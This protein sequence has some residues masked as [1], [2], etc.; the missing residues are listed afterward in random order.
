VSQSAQGQ[1]IGVAFMVFF[2][3]LGLMRRM[4]PQPVRERR[5]LITG[6][7]V[8]VAIGA[9]L[10]G[11]GGHIV[12]DPVALVLVPVFVAAG[13]GLGY[14]LVRSM[15]FWTDPRT[16]ALWMRGGVVFA[17]ILLG[18]I[19]L[20]FGIRTVVFGSPFGAQ[21]QPSHAGN[22]LLYDLSADLLFL[23]LGLWAAR[24]YFLV[25]RSRAHQAGQA[26]EAGQV[27]G[28]PPPPPA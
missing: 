14:Y 18:T 20:R 12:A 17:A 21:T 28:P 16:G 7:V 23:T 3:G 10:L 15:T 26:G 8:V 11:T 19:L 1:L 5:V 6:V 9:G 22:T 2:V 27:A 4:R 24:A 13:I 25:Q